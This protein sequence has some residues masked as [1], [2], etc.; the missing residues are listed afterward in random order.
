MSKNSIRK[1]MKLIVIGLDGVTWDVILPL[2]RK[3]KLPTF[4]RLMKEGVYGELESTIPPVTGPSWVSFATGRNPGKTGV[5][6]FLN[7]ED[8]GYKLRPVNSTCLRKISIW[9]YLSENG[10]RVG[11]VAFPVLF[12]P[13]QINGFMVSGM[14]A[15]ENDV[16]TFPP[17]L[18]REIDEVA[19]G[20]EL[21]V[22]YSNPRYDD[23]DLF[24]RD[25]NR[26]TDKQF[27]VVLHLLK[28]KDWDLFI[29]ICSATDWIQHL[30]W[31]HIDEKHPLYEEKKSL[32]YKGKFINF[33]QKIDGFLSKL[34]SFDANLII[35]SDHGFGPQDQCFNLA[36]WLEEKKYLVR[37][38]I[39]AK[40]RRKIKKKLLRVL[41]LAN[42]IIKIKKVLP[43]KVA[44]DVV[45]SLSTSIVDLIDFRKSDAFCLG[46]TIPFGAI[47]INKKKNSNNYESL[48][49][50][51]TENLKN[52]SN[53][54]GHQL[55]VDIYDPRK[56]YRGEKIDLAPDIIFSINNWRCVVL[57][58][59]FERPL[60]EE[61]P[62]SNRHTGSHRL[63][64]I[65]LA[66]GPDI[67]DSGDKLKGLKIYDITPTILYF[68]G[69]PIP[70]DMDGRVLR[71][72]FKE[73]S[74]ILKKPAIHRKT[75]KEKIRKVIKRLKSSH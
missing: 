49:L 19:G 22:R 61:K 36:K 72:I 45:I 37:R 12:P 8:N 63:N 32:T 5:F 23:E 14:M 10:Y 69:L 9:D 39:T 11:I 53:D 44:D 1:C 24:L 27:K 70:R 38:K 18:R 33:F 42:R 73:T 28:T 64:G 57:E 31:K 40:F 68:F 66:Y 48:K 51:I 75:E 52:L 62:Y 13:Y 60:F 74:E 29:Y 41:R 55:K 43:R 35:V 3:E 6:D 4:K 2:I 17:E 15:P 71:E 7:R 59:D 25:L 67:K 46:H 21:V 56:I 58:E 30:M 26:V 47:Y 16:I 50:K 65:F 20:Y 34:M 54:I